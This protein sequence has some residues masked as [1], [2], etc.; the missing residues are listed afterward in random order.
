MH[1]V[2]GICEFSMGFTE[3]HHR[4][5][6]SD[7]FL[8]SPFKYAHFNCTQIS[9]PMP[10]NCTQ[11]SRP[12][13]SNQVLWSKENYELISISRAYAVGLDSSVGIATR[14]GLDGPGIEFRWRRDFPRPSRPALGSTH[15]PI[16]WIPGVLW[17]KAAGAWLWPTTLIY[18]RG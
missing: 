13:P 18:G 12:M 5:P 16:R 11:I 6:S 17:G 7:I 10:S 9:R 15:P 8:H 2:R 1:P 14:Y 4:T 3:I